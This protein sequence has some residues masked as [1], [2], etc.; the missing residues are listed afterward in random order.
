MITTLNSL[1]LQM[2]KNHAGGLYTWKTRG[3]KTFILHV[4]KT[5]LN[6]V[7]VVGLAKN[8]ELK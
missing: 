6:F 3:L 5:E 2:Y 7:N 4:T 1:Y 8:L